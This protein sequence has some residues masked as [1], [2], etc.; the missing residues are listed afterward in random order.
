MFGSKLKVTTALMLALA[1]SRTVQAA[2]VIF[3]YLPTWQLDKTDGIDLSK[4]THVTIAFAIPDE[5]GQLSMD[6][7]D[8]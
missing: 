5:T 4:Y 3:G 1:A 2:D 7:R 8:A 6:N